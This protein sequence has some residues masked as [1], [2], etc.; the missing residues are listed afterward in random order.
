M[1]R[2]IM[3]F[4]FAFYCGRGGLKTK[5]GLYLGVEVLF[6]W[7]AVIP[8]PVEIRASEPWGERRTRFAPSNRVHGNSGV[9]SRS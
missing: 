2:N 6:W 5:Q 1:S 8:L 3:G 4:I 9:R 7:K